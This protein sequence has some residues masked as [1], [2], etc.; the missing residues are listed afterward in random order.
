MESL[1]KIAPNEVKV[2][3]YQYLKEKGVLISSIGAML[4]LGGFLGII[5]LISNKTLTM[6]SIIIIYS[7][8][9]LLVLGV[10][11]IWS[12]II[13]TFPP[14]P[15]IRLKLFKYI[16]II[17]YILTTIIT[18]LVYRNLSHLLMP[19]IIFFMVGLPLVRVLEDAIL[20]KFFTWIKTKSNNR[21]LLH[22]IA[23]AFA[24]LITFLLYEL[25]NYVNFA[26]DNMV[27]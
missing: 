17:L 25:T 13:Y 6:W 8:I 27:L 16:L 15:E 20:K 4:G 1:N 5:S 3:L 26:I 22:I 14:N 24:L 18:C 21:I 7:F 12:E 11:I 2:S 23:L 10:V 19:V 9:F